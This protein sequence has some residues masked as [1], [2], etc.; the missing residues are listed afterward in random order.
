MKRVTKCVI[1]YIISF[2][3]LFISEMMQIHSQYL[4]LINGEYSYIASIMK[5]MYNNWDLSYILFECITHSLQ[6]SVVSVIIYLYSSFI[7]SLYKK[8][9]AM[10]VVA[11]CM[12]IATITF[13]MLFIYMINN[14]T[15]M[16]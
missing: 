15:F 16:Y 12:I 1:I 2:V 8:S 9:N 5:E 14:L 11:T 7:I 10:K 4:K 6:L 13:I 3:L